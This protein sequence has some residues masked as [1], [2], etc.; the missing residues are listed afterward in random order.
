MHHD[1]LQPLYERI[2]NLYT[3]SYLPTLGV[4]WQQHVDA[5]ESWAI[6]GV[7][8]QAR[9]FDQVVKP[10]ISDT[11]VAVIFSDAFRYEAAVEFLDKVRQQDRFEAEL[12]AMLGSLPS[13]THV[14]MAAMLP[15]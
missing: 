1:V 10:A 11:K 6:P 9:F 8:S 4:N 15:Q 7:L 5:C 2:E 13:N 12:D 3:N 14:G